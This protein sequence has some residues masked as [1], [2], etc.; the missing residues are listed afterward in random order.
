MKQTDL[1][2]VF[3]L[4]LIGGVTGAGRAT[5]PLSL[6]FRKNNEKIMKRKIMKGKSRRTYK[7]FLYF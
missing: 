4:V 3:L 5:N 2:L 1:G 6:D 7:D